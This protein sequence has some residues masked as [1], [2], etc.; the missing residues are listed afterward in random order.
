[1]DAFGVVGVKGKGGSAFHLLLAIVRYRVRGRDSPFS[2]SDLPEA[3]PTT[4]PSLY[5][6]LQLHSGPG[7]CEVF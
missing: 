1:M 7:V 3:V 2:M 5:L 6:S 4:K